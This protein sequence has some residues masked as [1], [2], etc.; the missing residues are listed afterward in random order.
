MRDRDKLFT[1]ADIV[2]IN[3]INKILIEKKDSFYNK[4]F[5]ENEKKYISKGGDKATTIGGI[6]A[7]KEAASK[8][9]GTGISTVGWK[10]IEILHDERGKPYINLVGNGKLRMDELGID[11]MGLSISHEEEYAIAFVVAY[12]HYPNINIDDSIKRLLPKRKKESHKGTYGKVGIIAGSKGMTGAAYLASQSALRTGSGLVYT[13]I[14]QAIETIMSIKLTEAIIKPVR[15]NNGYLSKDS[16]DDILNEIEEMDAIAIGPG[17]GVD[18]EKMHIIEKILKTYPNPIVI[19]ADGINS[20]SFD[21][22]ILNNHISPIIIT[23]HPKEL[24]RLLSK[25]TREVQENRIYYSKYISS[26]YNIIVV[27]KGFNTIVA[28]PTGDIYINET[29]NPGMA[30]AGS[31]D[32]LTGI[33][34]SFIGQGIKPEDAAK[35]GVFC[36]GLAGD[37][38]SYEKGEYGVMATDILESIPYSIK[39]I[40][41]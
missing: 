4:I 3:R 37:L 34:A 10:D 17:I 2:N 41:G 9:L 14:P 18:K 31:G 32:I 11:N 27:L 40:L 30:T 13:I 20:I 19:D 39:K 26:K 16:L 8:A 25:S 1:G 5:T 29:G 24:A 7:A 12:S 35:L 21:L 38:A 23:P 6:F 22:N 15:D 33:I 28:L 36:H